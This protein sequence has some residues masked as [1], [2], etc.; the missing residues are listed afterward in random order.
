M[1]DNVTQLLRFSI[2]GFTV[3]VVYVSLYTLLFNAGFTPFAANAT[4]FSSAVMVQYIGQTCW[5]FRRPLWDGQQS[6]RFFA[7]I[8]L[9]MIYSTLVASLVGPALDWRPWFAA[10]VV[11]V[12]LPVINYIS[13]RL[14][15]YGPETLQ[16]ET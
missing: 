6:A 7:T 13:F 12:T 16:E 9:G 8:G 15:V 5:T 14:W 1:S 2:V 10:G 3:A 11:A 4:A